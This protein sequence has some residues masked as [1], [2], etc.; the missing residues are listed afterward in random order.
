MNLDTSDNDPRE[1]V[2]RMFQAYEHRALGDIDHALEGN[3]RL[4]ALILAACFID[5]MAH[6][7]GII[8]GS[9]GRDKSK[10]NYID[11][12]RKHMSRYDAEKLYED[13][14]CDLVHAY[15]GQGRYMYI[16]DR[17]E[18]HLREADFPSKTLINVED[19][20]AD[21]KAAFQRFR[22]EVL[23]DEDK[24][25]GVFDGI[26]EKKI[27][28]IEEKDIRYP[29]VQNKNGVIKTFTYTASVGN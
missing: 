18:V 21:V 5:Y 4:G 14:R 26:K 10:P 17:P 22:E 20:V 28:F 8:S 13:F 27:G 23:S 16:A 25:Q 11:F 3:S 29:V 19:F 7:A 15:S 9:I 24:I 6:I 1:L 12:V 2:E